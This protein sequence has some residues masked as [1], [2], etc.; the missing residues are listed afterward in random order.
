MNAVKSTCPSLT[1][2]G[3][4]SK[5]AGF[6]KHRGRIFHCITDRSPF[7]SELSEAA[8]G[9]RW[10]LI[11]P[12]FCSWCP[13]PSLLCQR[14]FCMQNLPLHLLLPWLHP[15]NRTY[16]K[17]GRKRFRSV[18]QADMGA[19]HNVSIFNT[20]TPHHG[21]SFPVKYHFCS[22]LDTLISV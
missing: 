16:P 4:T 5:S 22:G 7:S 14:S 2:S 20:H 13:P 18:P 9:Q 17:R 12:Q 15:T 10:P 11:L 21:C 8:H 1:A 6:H 3:V 19:K